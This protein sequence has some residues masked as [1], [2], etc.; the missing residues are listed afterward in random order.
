MVDIE[1][2]THASSS[3]FFCNICY[4]EY[5]LNEEDSKEMG[6]QIKMLDCGHAFC[7]HCFEETFRA[8]IEDQNRHDNL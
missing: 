6:I 7:N 8:M 2:Q 3:M 5:N 1:N 4:I